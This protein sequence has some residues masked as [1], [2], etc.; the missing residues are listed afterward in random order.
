M[1]EQENVADSQEM[2][3]LKI[4]EENVK[5]KKKVFNLEEE[6]LKLKEEL[7]KLKGNQ[8]LPPTKMFWYKVHKIPTINCTLFSLRSK[9]WAGTLGTKKGEN[10]V[11]EMDIAK[12]YVEQ[13]ELKLKRN[14][15]I[16]NL[17]FQICQILV[18]HTTNLQNEL[19]ET[20]KS[21]SHDQINL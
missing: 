3:S 13:A 7:R 2:N 8:R 4:K 15:D 5:L 20:R 11:Q 14:E 1:T 9:M 18:F 19:A 12:S 17:L 10:M 21:I 6:N 16:T